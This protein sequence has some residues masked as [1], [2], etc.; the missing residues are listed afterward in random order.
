[1]SPALFALA[2]FQIGSSCF[3]Q[4]SLDHDPPS[5]SPLVAGMTGACHYAFI[6]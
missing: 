5:Y 4:A 1:M 3:S 2:V 6:G